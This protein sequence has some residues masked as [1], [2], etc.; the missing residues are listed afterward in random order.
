[1]FFRIVY[2][3]PGLYLGLLVKMTHV[4][5]IFPVCQWSAT[6]CNKSYH[7]QATLSNLV[8]PMETL[9][10][11]ALHV[12]SNVSTLFYLVL[13]MAVQISHCKP[14]SD[15]NLRHS[16]SEFHDVEHGKSLQLLA[17]NGSWNTKILLML[18]MPR[19]SMWRPGPLPTDRRLR[20]AITSEI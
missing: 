10:I 12:D 9:M 15:E 6:L 11:E 1:M 20:R 8:N 18:Y 3:C 16:P 17:R 2:E 7:R 13:I 14:Q 5:H 19:F 4:R